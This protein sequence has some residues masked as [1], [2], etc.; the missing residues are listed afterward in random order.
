MTKAEFI[1]KIEGK[2]RS[3]LMKLNPEIVSLI[4]S[5]GRKYFINILSKEIPVL[6]M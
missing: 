4:Y 3:R 6:I 1:A 2:I 5:S